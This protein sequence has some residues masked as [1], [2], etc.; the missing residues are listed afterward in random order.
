MTAGRGPHEDR[1]VGHPVVAESTT[2]CGSPDNKPLNSRITTGD[3]VASAKQFAQLPLS[4]TRQSPTMAASREIEGQNS[5]DGVVRTLL[6]ARALIDST[7]SAHRHGTGH[8]PLAKAGPEAGGD[9]D[10]VV[11]L[12]G[13]ATRRV[14]AVLSGNLEQSDA[15]A[16]GI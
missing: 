5:S 9:G 10:S 15:V 16:A 12:I 2:S 6:E 11:R 1:R 4:Q 14:T 8:A 7:V 3:N 13:S